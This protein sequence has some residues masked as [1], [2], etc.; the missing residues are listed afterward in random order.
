MFEED[1]SPRA[2]VAAEAAPGLSKV[3]GLILAVVLAALAVGGYFWVRQQNQALAQQVADLQQRGEAQ[4]G[5]IRGLQR[6]LHLST[7]QLER[8]SETA[9]AVQ[10]RVSQTAAQL[11]STQRQAASLAQVQQQT[12]SDLNSVKQD[13]GSK[14]GAITGQITG[15]KGDVNTNQKAIAS[16]QAELEATKAQLKSTIGD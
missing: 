4:A 5:E 16:T 11:A 9:G 13:T 12:V 6:S 3:F 2:R 1:T 8:L 14:L 15:V 10:Q 7:A